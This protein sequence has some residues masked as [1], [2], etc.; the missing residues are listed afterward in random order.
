MDAYESVFQKFTVELEQDYE[1]R[2]NIKNIV[3]LIDQTERKVNLLVQSYHQ[4]NSSVSFTQVVGELQPIKNHFNDLKALIKPLLCY[5]YRDHWKS[6]MSTLSFCVLF[7]NW[8]DNK[9]LLK[10]EEVQAIFGLEPC[11]PGVLTIE[12]EDYLL[13][14]C[15]M[16]NELSRYCVNCVIK[17]DYQTPGKIST[18]VS[19]IFSGFRLLNLKNDIIRKRYDSMK[20]DLKRIEEVVYDISVRNLNKKD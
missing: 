4:A 19:D 2:Q 14:L 3:T 9:T 16:T 11:A 10:L 18:F 8:V 1:T 13:A 20:Y 17:E 15:N 6:H 5:K 12:L 7:S